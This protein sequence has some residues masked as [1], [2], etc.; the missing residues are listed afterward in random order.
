VDPTTGTIKLKA[1]FQ[2]PD[3]KLWPGQFVNAALQITVQKGAVTVPS[4]AVQHNGDGLFIY[5][6]KPD[7]TVAQQP[8]KAGQD[9]GQVAVIK[10]NIAAG[11]QVVINGQSRLQNG[12]KVAVN[13]AKPNS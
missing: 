5:V 7:S 13:P 3:N 2:N 11:A 6:L 1:E 4:A 10:E 12:T 9:D 8:V